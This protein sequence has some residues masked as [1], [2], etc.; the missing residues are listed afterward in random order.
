[1]TTYKQ[2]WPPLGALEALLVPWAFERGMSSV[3]LATSKTQGRCPFLFI[4]EVDAL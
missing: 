1:M 3:C 4:G 2:V